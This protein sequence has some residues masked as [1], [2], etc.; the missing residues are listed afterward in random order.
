PLQLE[1]IEGR[2]SGAPGRSR[3][4]YADVHGRGEIVLDVER[5][6]HDL[7]AEPLGELIWPE[8]RKPR[9][10]GPDIDQRDL[11]QAGRVEDS[12]C[13]LSLGVGRARDGASQ[14]TEQH[15]LLGDVRAE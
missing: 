7:P 11:S 3:L 10:W 9:R 4:R 6:R 14:R 15:A 1:Q 2:A 13:E 12:L 5:R 8:P